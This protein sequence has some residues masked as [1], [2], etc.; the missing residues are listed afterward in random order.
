VVA[1]SG[2]A[3]QVRLRTREEQVNNENLE[4]GAPHRFKPGQS[5]N[6]GGRPKK[7]PISERY[8]ELA[9]LELPKKDRIKQGLPEGATYGDALAMVM[10]KAALEGNPHAAREIR[11]AIEGKTGQRPEV[12]DGKQVRVVF[13]NIGDRPCLVKVDDAPY[14]T[15]VLRGRTE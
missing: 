1:Y 12:S 10:F 8:E 15:P 3:L 13:E 9:E 14:G 6:P 11:E 2:E 4:K 5:G 7:L